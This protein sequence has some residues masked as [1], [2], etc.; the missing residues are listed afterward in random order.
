LAVRKVVH[1]ADLM[2]DKKAGKLG[3]QTADLMEGY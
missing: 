1:L 3:F 2:V